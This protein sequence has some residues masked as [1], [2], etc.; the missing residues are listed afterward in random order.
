MMGAP[1]FLALRE[2][3]GDEKLL[4]ANQVVISDW[5]SR[6]FGDNVFVAPNDNILKSR[7][8]SPGVRDHFTQL[9]RRNVPRDGFNISRDVHA[10]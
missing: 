3:A 7:R 8:A 1:M 2:R 6:D 5:E 4:L 10:A 9:C